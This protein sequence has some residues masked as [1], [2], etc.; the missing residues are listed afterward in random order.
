MVYLFLTTGFETVEA[1]TA[2]DLLRRAKIEVTTVSITE[3]LEVTSSV[4]VTVKADQLF[5]EVKYET[6]EAL[7]LP[8]GPGTPS[9]LEHDELKEVVTK[10]YSSGKLLAA[11]CAAPTVLEAWGIQV[12]ATVYPALI[13]KISNYSGE[14]VTIDKNVI[15]G[16]ALASSVDFSLEIITY[17]RNKE[18]SQSVEKS[19]VKR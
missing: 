7:V 12:H 5:S 18:I 19:I 15:T 2:V 4:G 9:Y 11:I 10:H 17:L 6:A 8:G 16:E 3:K 13:D 1:L 14:R